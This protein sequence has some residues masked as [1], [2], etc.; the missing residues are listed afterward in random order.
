M[1]TTPDEPIEN[2]P[3]PDRDPDINPEPQPPGG[4]EPVP[5]DIEPDPGPIKP[6]SEGPVNAPPGLTAP[7]AA[8][9][10]DA[11]TPDQPRDEPLPDED[12][13]LRSGSDFARRRVRR[14]RQLDGSQAA[15]AERGAFGDTS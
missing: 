8:A 1:T 3:R 7:P 11:P 14:E 6:S 12:A 15:A 5:P 10:T 13:Q 9:A 2:P 4:G